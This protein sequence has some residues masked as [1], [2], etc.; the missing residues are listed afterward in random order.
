MDRMSVSCFYNTNLRNENDLSL[1]GRGFKDI[2][3]RIW[4]QDG[5]RP[6]LQDFLFANH[7]E[8]FRKIYV[9]KPKHQL[10]PVKNGT[11]IINRHIP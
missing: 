4:W 7:M 3:D 6:M 9:Q 1:K 5:Q 11:W 8:L 2:K 10:T